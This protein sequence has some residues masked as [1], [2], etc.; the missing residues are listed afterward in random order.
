MLYMSWVLPD[1][2]V[3]D[4]LPTTFTPTSTIIT[5]ST[6]ED[7]NTENPEDDVP[8]TP[9]LPIPL[10]PDVFAHVR[11]NTWLATDAAARLKQEREYD[12]PSLSMVR[13]GPARSS[14]R[15]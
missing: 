3:F 7:S 8:L 4:G 13:G 6:R 14:A 2:L 11:P 15:A 5:R 9:P 1:V 10:S 12:A